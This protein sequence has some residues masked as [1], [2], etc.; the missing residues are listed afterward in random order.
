M[1]PRLWRWCYSP[2]TVPARLPER[3]G[4]GFCPRLIGWG[5]GGDRSVHLV[6]VEIVC[7]ATH[8][9]GGRSERS[10]HPLG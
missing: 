4:A 1:S 9:V 8:E 7:A 6:A 2:R 3:G 10:Q 5:G